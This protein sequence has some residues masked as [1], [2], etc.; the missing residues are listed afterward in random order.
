MN[1]GGRTFLVTGGTGFIGTAL[2]AQLS[3][4]G[5]EV[6]VLT[7]KGRPRR[8]PVRFITS[9]DEIAD[10]DTIDAI[11]NL[12]GAS[13]ARRWTTAAK[14]EIVASRIDTT[15]ALA[16]LTG[17]LQSPPRTLIQASAI[18]YYGCDEHQTFAEDTPPTTR[19]AFAAQLCREWEAASAAIFCVRSVILRIGVVLDRGG[20]MLGRIVPAFRL[21]LGGPIGDGR[22]FLSWIHRADLLRL[23]I[24]ALEDDRFKGVY[25]A[26]APTPVRNADFTRALAHAVRRPAVIPAPARILRLIFGEMANDMLLQ[27]Q[28]VVP[29]R[30]LD[31]GF[32]FAYPD[33]DTA[34]AETTKP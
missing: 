17:R 16:A 29:Q 10:T 23:I 15:R 3:G 18:G 9:L 4:A 7:R 25:N 24:A 33:I 11:I 20:G 8:G 34:L 28:K 1:F 13:I 27:G 12:A 30:A 6:I 22:Q 5:G 26:T 2:I 32:W 21:G 19:G 31:Q 14:S